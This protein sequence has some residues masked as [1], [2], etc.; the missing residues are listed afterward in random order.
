MKNKPQ[1]LEGQ[2]DMFDI[3]DKDIKKGDSSNV[4]K[5]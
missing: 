5:D 3:I 1:I 4:R 2:I